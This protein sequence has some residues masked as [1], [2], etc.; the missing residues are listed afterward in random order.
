[1]TPTLPT[2]AEIFGPARPDQQPR[3]AL[4]DTAGNG[5]RE[6]A[7]VP[8]SFSVELSPEERL[9]EAG[10]AERFARRHGDSACYDHRRGRWLLWQGH[11]WA[12]DSDAAITR[13]A[14]D[15]A[16]TW[17]RESVELPDRTRREATFQAAIRLERREAL[18]SM[19]KLAAALHPIADTGD[20][21]DTDPWLLGTP[22]GVVDLRTSTL[23]PGQRADRI[24]MSTGVE[25]DPDA[26]SDRWE[27]ALRAI[28][29][30]DEAIDFL[31]LAL[32]YSATGDT[33]RDCWFLANGFGRNG[34][35][36]IYH[37]VR[38]ALGDYA[39]ELP[40]AVFDARR[41]GAPYDLAILP[42]KRF[43]V[44]SESGD[45]IKIHHDRIKQI[46][47]GDPVRAA[48]KYEKSFEF[49]PVCKLWL[50]A[51]R[52]PRVTD[53]SPAF[54]ARVMLVPFSVSFAG[55]EDRNLRPAL[56]QERAHQAAILAWIIRGA[57]RYHE[58]GLEPPAS[59]TDATALYEQECDPLADFLADACDV[60]TGAEIG[61]ADLF[62]HFKQWAERQGLTDRERLSAT[63]FGRRISERFPH[64][65]GRRG[66]AYQGLAPRRDGAV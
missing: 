6:P 37:P 59:V 3:P 61:A 35:G 23:R 13:L 15:F 7:A 45:T 47:G 12:P 46:T 48:N 18:V 32:G 62:A 2:A 65:R 55:R 29:L 51:N 10:A 43:V 11:R 31:Q 53:D 56:E 22:A 21:W 17:Q 63:A 26:R 25:Y 20:G 52:K 24:T 49:Q 60:A 33:R 27:A 42:G 58:H 57:A 40:A 44:S 38:R 66:K 9:T 50:A 4:G 41:D 34:K 14:L 64:T 16:R 5:R 54:W 28:L 36:T 39:A 1:M 30:S 19:L 8:M